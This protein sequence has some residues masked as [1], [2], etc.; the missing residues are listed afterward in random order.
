MSRG[1]TALVV[2]SLEHIFGIAD[3]EFE[4]PR[5]NQNPSVDS[6]KTLVNTSWQQ[7]PNEK[8]TTLQIYRYTQSQN[9]R[10][11]YLFLRF[12]SFFLPPQKKGFLNLQTLTDPCTTS[13]HLENGRRIFK[14]RWVPISENSF[15]GFLV[16][17][18]NSSEKY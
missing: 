14:L 8:N 15:H 10:R 6:T 5:T 16:G 12:P 3:G 11:F 13:I 17:G 4:Y 2:E 18:F 7:L 9:I 1:V